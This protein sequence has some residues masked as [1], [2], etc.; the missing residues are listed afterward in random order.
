[1]WTLLGTMAVVC[2]LFPARLQHPWIGWVVGAASFLPAVFIA[3]KL[4]WRIDEEEESDKWFFIPAI[5]AV[6]LLLIMISSASR[7][8]SSSYWSLVLL[9]GVG[10]GIAALF[11]IAL[12]RFDMAM[13]VKEEA[14]NSSQTTRAFGPRV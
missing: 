1:M 2:I 7:A 10:V 5:I 6:I 3:C 4:A 9:A 12:V 13:K 11:K 14:D 8:P